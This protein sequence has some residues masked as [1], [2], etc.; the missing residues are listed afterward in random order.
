[1][2]EKLLKVKKFTIG[3]LLTNC[4]L[5]YLD[6]ESIVIDPGGYPDDIIDFIS[7]QKIKVKFIINTHFH[8]D[9][10]FG[11]KILKEKTGA[12]ILIHEKEKEYINFRPDKFLKNGDK[13]FIKN[14]FLKVLHTPGHTEGSISLFGEN[15]IFSGD[16]FFKEG[17]GRTD[18]V[19]G[20]EE[21]L[22]NSLLKIFELIKDGTV[23]FPGHGETFEIKKKEFLEDRFKNFFK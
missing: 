20:S 1:M 5:V 7:K 19:G 16:T 21:K 22:K 11:N 9:H 6:K 10:T 18:L 4:Y 17:V 23:V 13:I 14:E 2:K 12:K 15:I 3:P 8:P